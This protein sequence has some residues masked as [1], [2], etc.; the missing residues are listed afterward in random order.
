MAQMIGDPLFE[1]SRIYCLFELM[2]NVPVNSNGHAGCHDT[3][4]VLH[5]YNHY[6]TSMQTDMAY[7]YGWFD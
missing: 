2:L 1:A 6:T 5:I 7:M 4:N 3:Q